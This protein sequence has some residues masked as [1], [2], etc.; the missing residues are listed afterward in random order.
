MTMGVG[1]ASR[2][3]LLLPVA[4]LNCGGQSTV[5]GGQLSVVPDP[6]DEPGGG[7]PAPAPK[8]PGLVQSAPATATGTTTVHART[9]KAVAA[10]RIREV[11]TA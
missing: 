9:E 3:A 8:S 2:A 6:D 1:L 11:L 10:I 7:Q 5:V 4:E